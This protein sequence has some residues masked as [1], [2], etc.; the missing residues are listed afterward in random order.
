MTLT[1]PRRVLTMCPAMFDDCWD[2]AVLAEECRRAA[3]S[4]RGAGV[5]RPA[6]SMQKRPAAKVAKPCGP[7]CGPKEGPTEEWRGKA[8][9]SPKAGPQWTPATPRLGAPR[10]GAAAAPKIFGRHANE[11]AWPCS[12]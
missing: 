2:E 9:K 10:N 8:N 6:A 5:K 3:S 7:K 11:S 12:P 4:A 1:P